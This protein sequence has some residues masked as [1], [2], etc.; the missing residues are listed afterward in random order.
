MVSYINLHLVIPDHRFI[1]LAPLNNNLSRDWIWASSWEVWDVVGGVV[2]FMLVAA[3][4]LA[5]LFEED[6]IAMS[7]SLIYCAS[8]VWLRISSSLDA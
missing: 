4:A 5:V 6:L 2:S 7:C 3:A 1:C 8:V